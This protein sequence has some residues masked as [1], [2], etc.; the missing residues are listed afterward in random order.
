MRGAISK[1]ERENL[2]QEIRNTLLEW[3]ELDRRVFSQAHYHGQSPETISSFFHLDV[4]EVRTILKEC[5]RRL[6]ASIK[7]SGGQAKQFPNSP[8]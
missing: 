5:D 6:N 1:I 7:K 8:Q 2:F 4:K 3:P